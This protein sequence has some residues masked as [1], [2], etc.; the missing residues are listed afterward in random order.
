MN[1]TLNFLKEETFRFDPKSCRNANIP[2]MEA[3]LLRWIFLAE[4][5]NLDIAQ[6][7]GLGLAYKLLKQGFVENPL[8]EQGASHTNL[9]KLTEDGLDILKT[10]TGVKS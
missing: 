3:K 5:S 10:V 9:W 4:R 6:S 7:F 2:L 1:N 8:G